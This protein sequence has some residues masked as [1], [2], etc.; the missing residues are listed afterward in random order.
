MKPILQAVLFLGLVIPSFSAAPTIDFDGKSGKSTK[1]ESL[2][3]ETLQDNSQPLLTSPVNTDNTPIVK[4]FE[5]KEDGSEELVNT[6]LT[7]DGKET[8]EIMPN[9]SGYKTFDCTGQNPNPWGVCWSYTF[10]PATAGHVHTSVD[11]YSYSHINP[12]NGK[13]L[14]VRICKSGLTPNITLKIYFKAPVFST[15]VLDKGEFSGS[16]SGTADQEGHITVTAQNLIQLKE[17]EPEPY[18]AFKVPAQNDPD[19][20][21]HPTHNYATPDTIVKF[22]QI[23]W[24]YNQQFSASTTNSK[25]IVNDMGLIW[26]G[27]YNYDSPWNCW[28]NGQH[29][30][31]HRY[32]RQMDVHTLTMTQEQRRCL[33]EIACKYQVR[34]ILENKDLL[35]ILPKDLSTL[36]PSKIDELDRVMHYHL[37]FTRPTD[38]VVVPPDD[39][40]GN[41]PS[42]DTAEISACPK[43]LG[44]IFIP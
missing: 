44:F 23:A 40:R 17:L 29:H 15:L 37:N 3:K 1:L 21:K 34:P 26:G 4:L 28:V 42:P 12:D 36:S 6:T 9:F 35:S 7:S 22:K 18:F 5:I 10:R 8:Y 11:P 30:F 14:P 25:L 33:E 43:P 31:Y 13:P 38:M 2:I 24:E 16:C 19:Q 39:D 20:P 32:G 41:C 27:R